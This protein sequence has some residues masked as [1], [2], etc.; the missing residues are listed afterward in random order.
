MDTALAGQFT[1][2]LMDNYP[3]D[4]VIGKDMGTSAQTP[5]A[6]R[7]LRSNCGNPQGQE[8]LPVWRVKRQQVRQL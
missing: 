8:R 6:L 3:A 5:S 7:R 2:V 1:M 4:G